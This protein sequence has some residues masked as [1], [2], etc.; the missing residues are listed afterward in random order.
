MMGKISLTDPVFIVSLLF[1]LILFVW[2]IVDV[3][4]RT[5]KD[6]REMA[7]WLLIV[8][9]IP[10]FGAVFYLIQGRKNQMEA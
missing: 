6:G 7:V 9:F 1:A 2:A 10:F 5:F 4:R 3:S 8:L